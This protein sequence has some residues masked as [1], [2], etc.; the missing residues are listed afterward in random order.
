MNVRKTKFKW[1]NKKED[2]KILILKTNSLPPLP[3]KKLKKEKFHIPLKP[4]ILLL[5]HKAHLNEQTHVWHMHS[6]KTDPVG[7]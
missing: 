4:V 3:K 1:W 7:F 2:K 5:E 6:M